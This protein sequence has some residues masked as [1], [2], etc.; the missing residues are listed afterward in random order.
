MGKKRVQSCQLLDLRFL[1]FV[2]LGAVWVD[3]SF[4]GVSRAQTVQGSE[5]ELTQPLQQSL[6]EAEPTEAED[7]LEQRS[8]LPSPSTLL[9]QSTDTPLEEPLSP[10]TEPAPAEELPPG[11]ETVAPPIEGATIADIQVQFVDEEGQPTEG[12]TR[13]FI[14]TREFDL[15][16]GEAYS[17][18]LAQEGLERV[19]RLSIVRQATLE[20]EPA[21]NG[22]V[23]LVVNVLESDRFFVVP[24]LT[25]AAPT[26]LQGP[27]R[28][29]TVLPL[30]NRAG[31]TAGGVRVG[32]RNIGGNNQTLSLG[33]EA[34]ENTLGFDLDFRDPWIAGSSSRTGY[35]IN[36][37]NQRG[38]AGV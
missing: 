22:Q 37:F 33:V 12:A 25:L 5:A 14:I 10:Q 21:E 15:E 2:A 35:A 8:L 9:T 26:A 30:S 24:G 32:L 1:V 11:G 29:V 31:G 6:T 28:P 19:T 36:L 4:A 23:V 27:A 18:D 17:Q 13:P 34:G 7:L 20:V 38:V 3:L 16:P